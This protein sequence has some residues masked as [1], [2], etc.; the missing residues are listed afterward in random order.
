MASLRRLAPAT[1]PCHLPPDDAKRIGPGI[2]A[3]AALLRGVREG[4]TGL[5]RGRKRRAV[6][7]PHLPHRPSLAVVSLIDLRRPK[8]EPVEGRIVGQPPGLGAGAARAH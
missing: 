4:R 1:R 6:E 7:M 2:P 8:T 5:Y 3:K